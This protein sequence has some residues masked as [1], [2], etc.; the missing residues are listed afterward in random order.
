MTD[1]A[2]ASERFADIPTWMALPAAAVGAVTFEIFH[3]LGLS[4]AGR[5]AAFSAFIMF[6][7]VVTCR[8]LWR[9]L[10]LWIFLSAVAALHAVII[11]TVHWPDSHYPALLMA[12]F[13][14][15]D[16]FLVL[17]LIKVIDRRLRNIRP[18]NHS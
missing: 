4:D 12:P 3:C 10:W 13:A 11:V 5:V 14:V 9:Q 15:A 17:G 16:F 18:S 8:P 6:G 7:V 2:N 1:N